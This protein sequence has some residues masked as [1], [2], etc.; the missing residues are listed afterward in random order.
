MTSGKVQFGGTALS[1]LLPLFLIV[2]LTLRL[3]TIVPDLHLTFNVE[4]FVYSLAI[5]VTI[6]V[7]FIEYKVANAERR[8]VDRLHAGSILAATVAFAGLIL[9]G[10]VLATNYIYNDEVINDII[11]L[12]LFFAIFLLVVQSIRELAGARTL[13][14]SPNIPGYR[15]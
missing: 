15:L 14:K 7:A 9:L 1:K 8:G 13:L 4:Q 11:S 12:Y 6:V 2:P 5:G 3:Q 10:F